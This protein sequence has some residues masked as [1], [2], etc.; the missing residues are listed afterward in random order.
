[1]QTSISTWTTMLP[2]FNSA[3]YSAPLTCG[4]VLQLSA[5]LTLQSPHW[6]YISINHIPMDQT[7]TRALEALQ[8]FIHLARSNSAGSPR[9]IANLI[10]N[11]TSSTQ[12]YVF[13]ELLEL[14]TVQA[15]R[16]PD[17]PAEFKGYLKLLEIFAWGTW[18]EYQSK[19]TYIQSP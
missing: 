17:T 1:M 13:A 6:I 18:Q 7:H 11:A 3:I 14:P 12:T 10:T 8:P 2:I 16:S 15:L 5:L 19:I 9:F 4:P